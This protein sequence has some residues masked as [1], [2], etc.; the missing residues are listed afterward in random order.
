MRQK[1]LFKLKDFD[2]EFG[3]ALFEK[4][5]RKTARP[6]SSRNAIHLVMRADVAKSGS[7]LM[8]RSAI[9]L[10]LQKLA[11]D[12]HVKIYACALVSSHIHMTVRFLSRGHYKKF[13]RAFTGVLAR[14]LKIKWLLRPYTRILS[15]GR[16]LKV[17]IEY[18][19]QNHLEAF[20]LIPYQPRLKDQRRTRWLLKNGH[21]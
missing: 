11:S 15:W 7:L 9:K 19:E 4:I 14:R 3:G 1:T 5:G 16:A 18:T 6:L 8:S 20:G 21:F 12:L 13:I 2:S 17:A 10:Y